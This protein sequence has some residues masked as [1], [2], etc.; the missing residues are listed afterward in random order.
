[1]DYQMAAKMLIGRGVQT[2]I[3]KMGAKGVY[4]Q[5]GSDSGFLPAFPVQA[6]DSVAA[7]DAFNAGFA[8]A[9]MEGK[10]MEDALRWGTAAGALACTRKG[11]FPSM[12]HRHEVEALLRS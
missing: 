1:L 2:V 9:L 5:S 8:V 10:S 6:I 11:A 4:F 3:L 7:G 12:P